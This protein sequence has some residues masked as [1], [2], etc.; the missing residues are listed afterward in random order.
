MTLW[1]N[2]DGQNVSIHGNVNLAV[3]IADSRV[4]EFSITEHASHLRYFHDQLGKILAEAETE[5]TV[6]DV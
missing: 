6:A 5:R 3:T 4:S 1:I 2:R